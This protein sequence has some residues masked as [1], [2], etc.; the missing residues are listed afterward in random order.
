MQRSEITSDH[1]YQTIQ[2]DLE[3]F[4]RGAKSHQIKGLTWN[5]MDKMHSKTSSSFSNNPWNADEDFNEYLDRKTRQLNK[6]LTIIKDG[7]M[8]FAFLQ[9]ID[10]FK[11]K[12]N[13]STENKQIEK[14]RKS[15]MSELTKIGWAIE[16]PP[17]SAKGG[18]QPLAILY[19]SYSLERVSDEFNSKKMIKPS[20]I[21]YLDDEHES[22]MR[23]MSLLL[24]HKQ[25][26][27]KIN[28]SNFHLKWGDK[29]DEKMNIEIDNHKIKCRKQDQI[30]IAGGDFNRP[31]GRINSSISDAGR[32]TN[33]RL[34]EGSNVLKRSH[35]Q[36]NLPFISNEKNKEYK[37]YDYFVVTE[38]QT[39][40]IKSVQLG[41]E[42]FHKIEKGNYSINQSTVKTLLPY[43]RDE[44]NA[45]TYADQK[46]IDK[47]IS[48]I[49]A[50]LTAYQTERMEIEK[51]YLSFF[52]NYLGEH[53]YKNK[54]YALGILQKCLDNKQQKIDEM[55]LHILN[56]GK[57]GVIFRKIKNTPCLNILIKNN[58]NV[59]KKTSHRNWK[60]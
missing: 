33:L 14:L 52:Y 11:R 16:Y 44:Q 13:N 54:M 38:G 47:L 29:H 53:S 45:C 57:L 24:K 26:D 32:T 3:T 17:M 36:E 39:S 23:G 60:T 1:T 49:K 20:G 2:V 30:L 40:H 25:S 51:S 34:D 46:S 41:G 18:Q 48:K 42:E 35:E 6:L 5:L 7:K 4:D 12:F 31:P 55:T 22:G 59:D 43:Q 27:R 21:I 37:S 58:L 8:D 10:V 15:F 50:E 28:L 56:T 9:E 19:N